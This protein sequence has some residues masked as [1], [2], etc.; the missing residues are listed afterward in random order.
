M[1]IIK[2]WLVYSFAIYVTSLI[3]PGVSIVSLWAAVI[4]AAVLSIINVF[5]KPFVILLTLPAT[6]LTIG[7]FLF[8]IN[9]FM[10]ML[11]SSIVGGFVV[12]NFGWALIFSIIISTI[13]DILIDKIK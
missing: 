10:I 13:Y 6:I 1:E 9:A 8:V 3:L 5:V 12:N 7:L 2:K 11:A 4:T